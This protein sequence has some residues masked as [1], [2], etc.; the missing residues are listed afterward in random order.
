MAECD[1]NT[2]IPRT[3]A[4]S[5][6][7]IAAAQAAQSTKLDAIHEQTTKT[8][9]QV[10]NLVKLTASHTDRIGTLENSV[11]DSDTRRRIWVDRTWKLA[12]AIGLVVLGYLL[13]G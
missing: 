2:T 9:G 11:S 1:P 6:Q 3:C 4:E 10:A 12:V 7:A 13:K 5:F 8:N